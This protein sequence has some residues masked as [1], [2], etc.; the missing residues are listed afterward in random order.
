MRAVLY[1]A[2]HSPWR[3]GEVADPTP[4]ADGVVL[5]V[6]S[7]GLCRSDW[8][9][10]HGHDNVASFPH[11]PGHEFAGTIAEV[12]SDVTRWRVGDRVAVP[13]VCA[14]G[15]C[16]VCESGNHQVCPHQWQPG[17]D[18]WGGFAEFV[19][20]PAADVNLV[21][22]PHEVSFDVAASLGCRVATAYRAVVTI[23]RV[24]PGEEVVVH[25]AG[26]VGLAALAI[27]RALGARVTVVDP[28]P[29]ARGAAVALGA[30][31]AL[32]P[33]PDLV[34]EIRDATS[35]GPHLSVEA[36]GDDAACRVS[37]E[38]LRPRGRH[39]QV[40]LL[41]PGTASDPVPMHRVIS[42]ELEVLGSHGLA[43]HDYPELLELVT[44]GRLRPD[45]LVAR[46]ISLDDVPAAFALIGTPAQPPGM[47]L[48]H[49]H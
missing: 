21:R 6:E 38:S 48:I 19:A 17:F 28:S 5:R 14:C 40:G 15:R 39:V 2:L 18:G 43:A 41:P 3:M 13:F 25:G 36:I 45:H 31:A 7:A 46:T 49:P 34:D 30:A 32:A 10:W 44:S 37:I 8:H 22:L 4:A 9:A 35:G 27:A 12:G 47:T 42:R 29:A 1:D 20:L 11:V 16:L 23:G 33:S 24:A 26:G